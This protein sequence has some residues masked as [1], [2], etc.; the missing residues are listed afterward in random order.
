M[1]TYSKLEQ[2]PQTLAPAPQ[3]PPIPISF[4]ES[5]K[6]LQKWKTKIPALLSSPSRPHFQ[7]WIQGT[8]DVLIQGQIKDLE[9]AILEQQVQD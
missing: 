1:K 4:S 7:N 9:H 8:E 5:E 2:A 6:L 3:L